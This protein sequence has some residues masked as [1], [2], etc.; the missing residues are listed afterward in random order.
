MDR[1]AQAID[2]LERLARPGVAEGMAR[3]G[4]ATADRV[5][6]VRIGDIRALAKR[7]GR[8]QPLAEALWGAGIYEARL[9]ACFVADPK[10]M[11][12]ELMDRW[13]G[14]FDNWATCDTACFH[15]FDKTP[16]A[17]A[18]VRE[19]AQREEE[20]V[21]R[22]GYVLLASLAIHA[23]KLGDRELAA[24]LPLIDEAAD[25]ARNFVKK[26]VSWA[27]RALGHRRGLHEEAVALAEI[28]AASREPT[29][30]WIGKDALRDLRRSLVARKLGL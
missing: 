4:I 20:F 26:G 1:I 17:L 12:P 7:M 6:G 9:L 2:E 13:T 22:A 14:D 16:Y 21:R 3:Y 30:R 19:W 8:D 15:L 5:V 29:R 18:K 28:L 27:L 24:F 10:A 11:T 25:D 23:K